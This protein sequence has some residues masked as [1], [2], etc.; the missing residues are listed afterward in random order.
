MSKPEVKPDL[1]GRDTVL[2]WRDVSNHVRAESA[3]GRKSRWARTLMRGSWHSGG[4]E[5]HVRGRGTCHGLATQR[6]K[7]DDLAETLSRRHSHS[8]SDDA[9]KSEA[10]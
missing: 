2:C 6:D 4:D 7:K 9:L 5:R 3:L 8:C 1:P 10:M